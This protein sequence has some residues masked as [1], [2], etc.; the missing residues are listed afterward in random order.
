MPQN[1]EYEYKYNEKADVYCYP[2]S[3]VL[4]N[5]FNILDSNDLNVVERQIT[6]LKIAEFSRAP[7]KGNFDMKYLQKIHRFILGDIYDFAG[8]IREGDFLIKGD[9]IFCRAMYIESMASEIFEQLC[10]QAGFSLD[11][12][13]TEKNMLIKADIA[14]FNRDYSLLENI[15]EEVVSEKE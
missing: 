12:H 9:S 10:D 1:N 4:I 15:L 5:K 3:H 14:A 7:I 13:L 8:E 2:N 11:F 6:A